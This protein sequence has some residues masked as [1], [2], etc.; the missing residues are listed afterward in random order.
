MLPAGAKYHFD[1]YVMIII[2]RFRS[3]AVGW[4]F[5]IFVRFI[6]FFHSGCSPPAPGPRLGKGL[7]LRIEIRAVHDF[8]IVSLLRRRRLR[9]G[10]L[11]LFVFSSLSHFH[12]T[13]RAEDGKILRTTILHYVQTYN[14]RSHNLLRFVLEYHH[15]DW[16]FSFER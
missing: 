4:Y 3:D 2:L 8:F 7:S 9:C 11:R 13:S 10:G 16:N 15:N 1:S 12:C 5:F 14:F 6:F